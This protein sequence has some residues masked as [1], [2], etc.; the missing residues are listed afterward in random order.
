LSACRCFPK[1]GETSLLKLLYTEQVVDTRVSKT[2]L[3]PTASYPY[4]AVGDLTEKPHS[5]GDLTE[6]PLIQSH[7]RF[8]LV[9][10]QIVKGPQAAW[11]L[12][13]SVGWV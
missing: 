1:Y 13:G 11:T 10:V 6:K 12:Q 8:A 2:R 3:P 7:D 4:V 9:L 5:A